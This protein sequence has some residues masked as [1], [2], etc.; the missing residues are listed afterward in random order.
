MTDGRTPLE[1]KT[2]GMGGVGGPYAP[3]ILALPKLSSP[4]QNFM[5]MF[6]F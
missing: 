3:K 4:T 6:P 1:K 5:M 2:F